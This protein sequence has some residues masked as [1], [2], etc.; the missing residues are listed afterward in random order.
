ML[1]EHL[2]QNA[3]FTHLLQGKS[4]HITKLKTPSESVGPKL[5]PKKFLLQVVNCHNPSFGL[6][7]KVMAC[8]GVGQE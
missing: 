6:V 8:K 2:P 7:T 4:H 1:F 5:L 3:L